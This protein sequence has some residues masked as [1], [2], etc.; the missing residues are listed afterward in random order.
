MCKTKTEEKINALFDELVP[1]EGKCDTLAGEIIR[2]LCRINY[3]YYNDGDR[4][5]IGYGNE[6]CNAAARFL[7]EHGNDKIKTAVRSLWGD[8][9]EER[10]ELGL[11]LLCKYALEFVENNPDLRETETEDMFD[12]FDRETDYDYDEEEY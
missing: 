5:G 11:E 9:F 4:I 3:R 12:W 10:Y 1:F 6:T 7:I 8:Y 2:A